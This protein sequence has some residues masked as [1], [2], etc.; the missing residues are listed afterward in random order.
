MVCISREDTVVM[1]KQNIN[2][3][4][5]EEFLFS[6]LSVSLIFMQ[7]EDR[8][9]QR[10]FATTFLKSDVSFVSVIRGPHRRKEKAGGCL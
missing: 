9:Q 10:Q 6:F 3:L 2:C 7:T 8:K 4:Q 1:R 5:P